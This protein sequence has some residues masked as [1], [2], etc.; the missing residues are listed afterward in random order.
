M[1]QL[2]KIVS[3]YHLSGNIC[4]LISKCINISIIEPEI[5]NMANIELL[6]G[7]ILGKIPYGMYTYK[8]LYGCIDK[9]LKN[10]KEQYYVIYLNSEQLKTNMYYEYK[11]N[12]YVN[13]AQVHNNVI[14]DLINVN[15]DV[16]RIVNIAACICSNINPEIVRV[17]D[18]TKF[19]SIDDQDYVM[20]SD[21]LDVTRIYEEEQYNMKLQKDIDSG[22]A[23]EANEYL[24]NYLN[25][26]DIKIPF[27]LEDQIYYSPDKRFK[28]LKELCNIRK[29]MVFKDWYKKEYRAVKAP[30]IM[31]FKKK[32]KCSVCDKIDS[33]ILICTRCKNTYY[34]STKCQRIDYPNHKTIC[35]SS[36]MEIKITTPPLHPF[37][38]TRF[39][40]NYK[41]WVS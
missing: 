3:R 10:T 26:T 9:V 23:N 35:C 5:I 6:S 37:R 12:Y 28:T 18:T 4:K 36:T 31:K 33:N 2:A 19:S 39:G 16:I 29:K 1:N 14:F 32:N 8:N 22:V 13:P 40:D 15:C 30:V 27:D 17:F 20:I 25:N 7:Q 41:D 24:Q 34:C 11:N 38:V 21:L